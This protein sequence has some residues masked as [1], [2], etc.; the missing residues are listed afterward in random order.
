MSA[1]ALAVATAEGNRLSAPLTLPSGKGTQYIHS[2]PGQRILLSDAQHSGQPARMAMKRHGKNLL[3]TVPGEDEPRLV[4]YDFYENNAR[5]QGIGEDGRAHDW[6]SAD[7]GEATSDMDDGESAFLMLSSDAADSAP[8]FVPEH[9][10]GAWMA[11]AAFAG[12]LGLGGIVRA[13]QN[14]HGG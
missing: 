1:S 13:M 5:L 4:I 14:Q 2:T 6:V 9:N 8:L 3:L 11:M 7:S 12:L 10:S